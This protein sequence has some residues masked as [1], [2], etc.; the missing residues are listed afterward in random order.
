MKTTHT[1]GPW[2]THHNEGQDFDFI[3]D[4]Y[5]NCIAKVLFSEYHI[6]ADSVRANA[7]LIAA[8]PTM[9]AVLINWVEYFNGSELSEVEAELKAKSEELLLKINPNYKVDTI[10]NSTH[11]NPSNAEVKINIDL[12]LLREQK[13]ALLNIPF[14]TKE[15]SIAIDGIIHTID[16]IQDYAADVLKIDESYI[17][18]K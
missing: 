2:A 11:P 9:E 7:R 8:A 12:P 1:P 10:K 16:G 17:Y 13:Q 14:N 15:Q 4:K 18:T 6:K 3:T 5:N